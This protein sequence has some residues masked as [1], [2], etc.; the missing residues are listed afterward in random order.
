METIK[1]TYT[2]LKSMN[3]KQFVMQGINLGMYQITSVKIIAMF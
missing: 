2:A 3:K 1:E